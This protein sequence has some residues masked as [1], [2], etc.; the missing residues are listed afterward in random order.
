MN[1]KTTD[2]GYKGVGRRKEAVANL[3][4]TGG[5]GVIVINNV[6]FETYF[7]HFSLQ[8]RLI[9]PLKITN[10][11]GKFD[12]KARVIGGG[13]SGQADACR[14]AIAK[15]I[16]EINPELRSTLKRAKMLTRDARIKER[17]KYGLKRARKAAQFT[18]R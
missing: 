7:S 11:L 3:T 9:E 16:L 2:Q 15:A 6:P 13:K 10:L 17:K 8:D 1:N 4:L 18:K 5:K 14:L 12:I